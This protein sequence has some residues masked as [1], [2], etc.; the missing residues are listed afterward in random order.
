MAVGVVAEFIGDELLRALERGR[1]RMGHQAEEVLEWL[2]EV[3]KPPKGLELR[4]TDG[5]RYTGMLVIDSNRVMLAWLIRHPAMPAGPS[6]TPVSPA[7]G[8]R[9]QAPLATRF[10]PGELDPDDPRWDRDWN[11]YEHGC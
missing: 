3:S 1:Q 7:Y 6:P 2:R 10:G 9:M 4:A 8:S 5:V 11:P